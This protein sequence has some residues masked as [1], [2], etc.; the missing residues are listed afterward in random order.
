MTILFVVCV[1][2]NVSADEK[3]NIFKKLYKELFKYSTIYIAGDIDNPKENPKDY[4]V[5][6]NPDGNLYAPPV[7]VD[8]TDY[9]DFDYRYGFGIRK[10]ARFDYEIKGKHYYDGTENNIGLSAPNSP[11][12]GLEYTF[13]YEKERS[14]DEVYVNHRYFI[15]H[16]GNYH[17]VKLESRKQGRVDFNYNSA[18][19]RAKL[20]I[21]KK[22]SLSAG[23][24]YRT[25]ERPYGYNPIEIWL[26]ETNADGFPVNQW[27]QLGYQY[28]YTDQFVTIDI[29]GEE[30][31]DWYWYNEQGDVVALSDLQFRDTVFESLIN[32]YNNEVWDELDAFGVVSPILGFD[33][34]HYKKNF[35]L[36]AYGSYLLP[37]HK[38]VKGDIDFSYL[39]RNN[40]GLGGLRQD[41][42]HEQ[43]EDYQAG[44]SFG[45]KLSKSIGV[46]VEGEYT[47]F[48][49]SQI[50]NSSVGLN[51]RL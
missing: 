34:Y 44:V 39:N 38:Y 4:F 25:H 50:Y 7:V 8:G 42:E 51:F 45:W 48:W 28:G 18:E 21:G 19:I 24:I 46:F 30:T 32:R 37:Y 33:F 11:V 26:N 29:N 1:S 16:S 6:T 2:W 10:L 40:W 41:S 14:R 22:F 35:W 43:W 20:P 13:H 3:D 17:V 9:Y 23:A 27:Y 12:S 15:K 36:H 31:F 5:R 47:K 49:D